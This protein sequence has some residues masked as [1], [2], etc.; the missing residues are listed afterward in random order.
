VSWPEEFELQSFDEAP[1]LPAD[2]SSSPADPPNR[3]R[4]ARWM[5]EVV[6]TAVLIAVVFLLVNTTTGRFKIDGSSMEPN[7]HHE[8]YVIVDKVT[9]QFDQPQRG[10][11][12][13]FQRDDEERDYIKRVIGL[14]GET[15]EVSQGQVYINGRPLDEPYIH[16]PTAG[17]VHAHL[18]G[19]DE[20][21]VMG[22]NRSNSKDSRDFGAIR[23][24]DILGRAWIVYWPPADWTV[25]PHYT[26]AASP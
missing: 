5:Q 8:E 26:S 10:D 24:S 19:Q 17:L 25:I 14:P 11:V 6:D 3:P 23:L 2:S 12:I 9:Y 1:A 15:L 13:V 18:L 21:F 4:R 7:L 20:Y 16:G 22:D